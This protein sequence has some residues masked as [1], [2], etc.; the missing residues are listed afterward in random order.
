MFFFHLNY[1]SLILCYLFTN[2]LSPSPGHWKLNLILS[3]TMVDCNNGHHC[4][5]CYTHLPFQWEFSAAL[6]KKWNLLLYPWNLSWPGIYRM[7]RKW[8]STCPNSRL[9]N[10][11]HNS[12]RLLDS[13]PMTRWRSPHGAKLVHLI[14]ASKGHRYVKTL[15]QNHQ[16]VYP[17]C[18]HLT[19]DAQESSSKISQVWSRSAEMLSWIMNLY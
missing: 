5:L 17:I 9:Q 15:N 11:L 13:C 18:M 3:K 16:G 10:A 6:I 1:I 12:M 8:G 2:H 19:T 4:C 14:F 7:K